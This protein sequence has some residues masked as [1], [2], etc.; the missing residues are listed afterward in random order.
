[1][2]ATT[3]LRYIGSLPFFRLHIRICECDVAGWPLFRALTDPAASA[4][5]EGHMLA[6]S[7]LARLLP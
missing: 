6:L 7:L 3:L 4:M 5:V 2:R 1:M